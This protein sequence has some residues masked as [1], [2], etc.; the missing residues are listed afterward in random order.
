MVNLCWYSQIYWQFKN[1]FLFFFIFWMLTQKDLDILASKSFQQ[2]STQN[3]KTTDIRT[4]LKKYIWKLIGR[5]LKKAT[6]DITRMALRWT[7]EGKWEANK[8][9][10]RGELSKERSWHKLYVG[11]NGKYIQE[12]RRMEIPCPYFI[13]LREQQRQGR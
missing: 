6:N 10:N 3:N 1:G 9:Q 12:Q 8:E 2:K 13:C 4:V 5:V 7:L 11:R